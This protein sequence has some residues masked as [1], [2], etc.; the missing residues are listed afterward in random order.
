MKLNQKGFGLVEGLLVIITLTLIVGVGF[1]VVNANKDKEETNSTNG[2][3]QADSKPGDT[4]KEYL[5][6]KELGVKVKNTADLSDIKFSEKTVNANGMSGAE[7]IFSTPR[8]VETHKAC[9]NANRGQFITPTADQASVE[10]DSFGGKI[11]RD[12]GNFAAA[13]YKPV[14]L[15][16]QFDS[17]HIFT[18][19]SVLPCTEDKDVGF[20]AEFNRLQEQ[21]VNAFKNAEKL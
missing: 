4:K 8:L 19:G 5:E 9:I 11:Y 17:F 12:N 6:F 14:S 7:L 15:V 18:A 13:D 10:A 2:S 1:Y 3:T 16:K 20:A 21:V